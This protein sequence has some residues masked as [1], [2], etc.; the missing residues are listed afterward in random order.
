M[1]H[2]SLILLVCL[3]TP[4]LIGALGAYF[5]YPSISS[6]YIY[7]QKPVISPPNWI[8]GPVWTTL[9]ILMGISSFLVFQKGIN[10]KN[11]YS[12]KVYSLQLLLNLLWS[13]AFF[14]FRSIMGGL[15]VIIFLWILIFI[16]IRV[17]SKINKISG[18]LLWPYI[19]WVSFASVLN[20]L[21]LILNR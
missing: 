9:Y 20:L 19:A 16:N 11:S 13:I 21:L 12:L 5:T 14:G 1:F 3:F 2:K 8:F 4:L 7:L 10:K 15:I 17:F 18:Y 6:W